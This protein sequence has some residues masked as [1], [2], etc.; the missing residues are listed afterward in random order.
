MAHQP[1]G[2][3]SCCKADRRYKWIRRGSAVFAIIRLAWDYLA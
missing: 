1:K 3:C 2:H